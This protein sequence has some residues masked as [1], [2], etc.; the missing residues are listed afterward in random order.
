MSSIRICK[1]IQELTIVPYFCRGGPHE[2]TT[3]SSNREGGGKIVREDYSWGLG[4]DT[5]RN[6][7]AGPPQKPWPT[8]ALG[9]PTAFV[10]SILAASSQGTQATTQY[11]P[12]T[13]AGKASYPY[14]P[15]QFRGGA[16][17]SYA[18]VTANPSAHGSY[19]K[20]YAAA[21]TSSTASGSGSA[22][23]QAPASSASYTSS[24][25]TEQASPWVWDEDWHR[26]KTLNPE[27]NEWEWAQTQ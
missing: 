24:A 21:A 22:Y 17:T 19:S 7:G 8:I 15:N 6:P 23:Y 5:W 3:P 13:T 1:I 27:T 12:A 26:Y 4:I 2:V 20:S 10:P 16:T 9:Q 25:S 11:A 18:P 14:N